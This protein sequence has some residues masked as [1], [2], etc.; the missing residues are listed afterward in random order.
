[1]IY[2]ELPELEF[3]TYAAVTD[4]QK[5]TTKNKRKKVRALWLVLFD[6]K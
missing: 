4:T 6:I 1:M 2:F 5:S 3:I